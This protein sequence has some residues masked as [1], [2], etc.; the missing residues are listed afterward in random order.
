MS[1]D[2]DDG[3]SALIYARVSSKKQVAQGHGLS[4]QETRCRDFAKFRGLKVVAAYKDDI[5]GRTADRR[6]MNEMLAFLR[7]HRKEKFVV[8]IDDVSRLGRSRR[9]YWELRDAIREVGATLQSPNIEFGTDADSDFHEGLMVEVSAHQA[10]KNAE[11]TKNRM[12]SRA[13]EGWWVFQPPK[14]YRYE[15]IRGQ[16]KTLVRDEPHASIIA[17]ALN[18]YASGRFDS[19]V[20]VK[21]F[22]ESRASWPK[23]KLGEV[24]QERVIELFTRP[25]Y[26]GHITIPQWGLH[27][28]PARHE[29]LV[30]L[31]TW[32]TV[33]DRM[34]GKPRAPT[35]KDLR[36]GF[37]LR[38]FVT[39]SDCGEAYT[40]CW[41]KGRSARY[42]YY[43]CDTRGCV[44][45]RKSI[46]KEVLEGQFEELLQTLQPSQGLFNLAF[47]MI[48]DIW[49]GKIAGARVEGQTLKSEIATVG[50]KIDQLL[51]RLVDAESASVIAAYERKIE[52]LQ[53]QKALLTEKIETVGKPRR[54]FSETYRTARI[55]QPFQMLKG[56]EMREN[57]AKRDMVPPVGL[58]PTCLAAAD[59]ESAASTNSTTGARAKALAFRPGARNPARRDGR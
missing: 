13:K 53:S 50:R 12:T 27:L 22:L 29:P 56:L 39:C 49:D 46:R 36:A 44:S 28:I 45:Y 58:E 40:S 37:P 24:P 43:L 14:G 7:K 32:L 15:N 51:E 2:M 18:G 38:N 59:F 4:S 9:A 33:Q 47:Q 5:T 42:P 26:A 21:R 25:I 8:I 31:E 30:T 3:R 23:D 19:L 57:N 41:S 10:T 48:R 11:T 35:R 17:E 20:E 55:S 6:E 34:M 16:G 54:S 1:D 52:E